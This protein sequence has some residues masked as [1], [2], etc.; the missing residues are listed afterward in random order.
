MFI[1]LSHEVCIENDL[2]FTEEFKGN[3]KACH[4]PSLLHT[5][6]LY[7]PFASVYAKALGLSESQIGLIATVGMLFQV[8]A[9][10]GGL[11]V[12][13]WAQEEHGYL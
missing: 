11:V 12:T 7:I 6:N 9:S 2:L 3:P 8:L 4:S 1:L 13:K 10:L 5:Y